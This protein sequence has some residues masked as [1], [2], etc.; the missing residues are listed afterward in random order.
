MFIGTHIV[1]LVQ[2]CIFE[3]AQ[4][5]HY[6]VATKSILIYWSQCQVFGVPSPLRRYNLYVSLHMI[7]DVET[8]LGDS[9]GQ[10]VGI[11]S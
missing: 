11:V 6:V 1:R 10:F 9:R 2:P 4:A 3:E 8:V 7:C 5:A